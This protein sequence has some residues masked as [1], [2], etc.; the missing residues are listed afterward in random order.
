MAGRII[1]YTFVAFVLWIIIKIFAS[2]FGTSK[3]EKQLE[4]LKKIREI[5]EQTEKNE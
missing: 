2:I 5:L 1:I 4:E 3:S